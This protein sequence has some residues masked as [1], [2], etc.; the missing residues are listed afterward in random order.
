MY[1]GEFREGKRHGKGVYILKSGARYITSLLTFHFSQIFICLLSA[2]FS[3]MKGCLL[4]V[5]RMDLGRTTLKMAMST[6]EN[7]KMMNFMDKEHGQVQKETL[8]L[9]NFLM[10]NDT[11]KESLR[12]YDFFLPLSLPSI[13]ETIFI[14]THRLLCLLRIEE[15]KSI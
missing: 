2:F 14:E 9:V 12:K 3:G 13:I 6:P 7:S 11:E 10:A 4:T 8:T 1:K 15:R 5:N